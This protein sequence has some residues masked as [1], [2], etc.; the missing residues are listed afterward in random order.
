MF[1]RRCTCACRVI[2]MVIIVVFAFAL[3]LLTGLVQSGFAQTGTS[4]LNLFK[5][6]F[7]TGDYVVAGWVEGSPDGSGYATGSISIPDLKQPSQ[8]GVPTTVPKG[9][10]IVAAYLYWATV[11]SNQS[12]F[13]GQQA[14]FNGYSITGTVLGNPNAPVSWSAGGC[15]GSAQGSKTMRTYRADVHPYLPLDTNPSSQTFGALAAN[16]TIPVRL[17]DSGSNGNTALPAT[18]SCEAK[19]SQRSSQE[20]WRQAEPEPPE[21]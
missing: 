7:V 20:F 15:S 6:Y 10:D 17:A 12:S 21:A 19:N 14:Y 18:E 16:G 9:A 4:P 11:E 5:N 8:N 13:A 1:S 2:R 3:V